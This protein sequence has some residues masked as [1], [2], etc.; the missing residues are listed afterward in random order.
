MS[1]LDS[2]VTSLICPSSQQ[3]Y[4]ESHLILS[5][6][7]E[8]VVLAWRINHYSFKIVYSYDYL[9]GSTNISVLIEENV[10]EQTPKVDVYSYGILLCEVFTDKPQLPTRDSYGTMLKAIEVNWSLMHQL[11]LSCVQVEPHKR[12][13]MKQILQTFRDTFSRVLS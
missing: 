13:T 6:E 7:T 9:V 5:C 2:T 11:I 8:G 12:P 4:N 10:T 1:P 3:C